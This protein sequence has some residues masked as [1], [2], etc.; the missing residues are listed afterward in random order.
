MLLTKISWQ[1]YVCLMIW[2]FSPMISDR[3]W[4]GTIDEWLLKQRTLRWPTIAVHIGTCGVDLKDMA[5]LAQW[6]V[7]AYGRG[8]IDIQQ[9]AQVHKGSRCW[10]CLIWW[11]VMPPVSK[12]WRSEIAQQRTLDDESP[13]VAH[14]DIRRQSI[15][16]ASILS[17]RQYPKERID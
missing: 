17:R 4:R 7:T 9:L 10:W 13:V 1:I 3:L 6:L 5:I 8:T 12:A 15:L 2:L 16:L 14:E 11:L